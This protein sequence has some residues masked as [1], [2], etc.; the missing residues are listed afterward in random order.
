MSF[1]LKYDFEKQ[2]LRLLLERLEAG[3]STL[4]FWH[5]PDPALAQYF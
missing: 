2:R 4:L 5:C 3:I 1:R